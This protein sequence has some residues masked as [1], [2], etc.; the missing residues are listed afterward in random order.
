V[1]VLFYLPMITDWF[2]DDVVGPLIRLAAGSAEVHVAV[3]LPWCG[4]GLSERQLAYCADLPDI[5]WHV[6]DGDD[7][8]SLRSRPQSPEDLIAFVREI[9]PDYTFC[10]SADVAT[11]AAFPGAVRFLMEAAIP[12][13]APRPGAPAGRVQLNGPNMFDRGFIPSLADEERAL[14]S[15]L[16]RT[17]SAGL[18]ERYRTRDRAAYCAEAGLPADRK[19]IA[20]PLDCEGAVNF[21]TTLNREVRSNARLVAELVAG[22]DEEFVLAVTQHP[23][24]ARLAREAD[25][26]LE[27][28]APVLAAA[29]DRVRLVEATFGSE[30]ATAALIQHADGMIACDSKA[31]GYAAFFGTP[32]LRL[33]RF[34][35]ADWMNVYRDPAA[36]QS[37]IA[38][39]SARKPDPDSAMAW[40]AFHYA[41][42]VFAAH[43]PAL[44]FAGL[45]SRVDTP[46]DVARWQSGLDR[47][48]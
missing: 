34:A 24:N 16:A 3:P 5:R 1:R 19:I 32:L 35:S 29:G 45:I 48:N 37:A 31:I 44:T 46:V 25:R 9:D 28:I 38:S 18:R 8:S 10:R 12:P 41:N 39:G 26:P 33:S 2:F 47:W 15:E 22:I 30:S 21:F 36:F 27:P 43:D 17:A 4:T 40:L 20:L 14:L 23:L 11:P 7:H 6:L 42:D 13:F